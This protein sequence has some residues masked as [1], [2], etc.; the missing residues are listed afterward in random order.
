MKFVSTINQECY[1]ITNFHDHGKRTKHGR[2]RNNLTS[3]AIN[4]AKEIFKTNST[5]FSSLMIMVNVD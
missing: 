4:V 1:F 2:D 5:I 3:V